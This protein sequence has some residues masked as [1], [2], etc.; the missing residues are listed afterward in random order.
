MKHGELNVPI[1]KPLADKKR[2]P[3]PNERHNPQ[4]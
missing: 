3:C 2:K 1:P 4:P